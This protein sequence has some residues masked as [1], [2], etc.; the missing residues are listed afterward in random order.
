MSRVAGG[1]AFNGFDTALCAFL[2]IHHPERVI[3]SEDTVMVQSFRAVQIEF[4]PT[5]NWSLQRDILRCNPKFH[6][7]PRYDCFLYNTESELLSFAFL[8]G[9]LCCTIPGGP[10][11]DLVFVCHFKNSK[12]KPRIFWR[13]CRVVEECR[14]PE[15]LPLE[16]VAR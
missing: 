1:E 4:Q 9:L 10:K 3:A 2:A 11:F 7:R 15:F 8:I 13:G 5:V 12:W 14:R 6:G 16:H